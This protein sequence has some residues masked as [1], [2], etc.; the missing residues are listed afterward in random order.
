MSDPRP[1]PLKRKPTTPP[2]PTA[3]SEPIPN[4]PPPQLLRARPQPDKIR[5]GYPSQ[6]V[7]KPR[8][9][10]LEEYC[11]CKMKPYLQHRKR[12][13]CTRPNLVGAKS[14]ADVGKNRESSPLKKNTKKK[15]QSDAGTK[16][17]T[18]WDGSDP[19]GVYA[20]AGKKTHKKQSGAGHKRRTRGPGGSCGG[21]HGDFGGPGGPGGPGGSDGPRG[22]GTGGSGGIAI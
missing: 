3:P 21:P 22:G 10:C 5:E 11:F 9:I 6:S 14:A 7:K 16:R 1:P 13:Q 20:E 12:V 2:I 15:T 18:Q 19:M 4:R 8:H 17:G